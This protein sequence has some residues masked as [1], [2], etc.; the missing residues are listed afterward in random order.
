MTNKTF[1]LGDYVVTK[2]WSCSNCK[3]ECICLSLETQIEVLVSSFQHQESIESAI[4]S[5]LLQ[6]FPLDQL[7]ITLHDDGSND[8]TV[9]SALRA[10]GKSSVKFT[11]LGRTQNM[12]DVERFRFFFLCIRR[13]QA[14]Y[15]AFLDG[16]DE[17]IDREKLSR[18]IEPMVRDLRVSIVHS[19]YKVVNKLA[20]SV[21][22]QPDPALSAN[23]KSS[24]AHL[25]KENFIGTLTCVVRVADI[26]WDATID[27][28]GALPVGDY[29]IWIMA[30]RHEGSKVVFLPRIT[31]AYYIHGHN[32][33]ASGSVL[34]KLYKTRLLQKQIGTLLSL[35]VGEPIFIHSLSVLRRRLNPFRLKD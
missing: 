31:A 26:S 13:S 18:Q 21:S 22:L 7:L 16:D 35:S 5:I 25:R 29:P 8:S 9:E 19:D 30:T 15:M 1:S 28:L 6:D 12:F 24:V 2:N 32:Y 4:E 17:W 3:L 10:L 20:S 11:I 14:K 27:E 33:W 34:S 23:K